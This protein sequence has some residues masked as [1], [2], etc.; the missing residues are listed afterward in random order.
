APPATLCLRVDALEE[1]D[2]VTIVGL[3][4]RQRR[5][6]LAGGKRCTEGQRP[7]KSPATGTVFHAAH[8]SA[9]SNSGR[10]SMPPCAASMR[11]SGCGISP[12]TLPESLM[13][14]AM[15]LIEPFGLVCS[16]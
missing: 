10:P 4:A 13:M 7:Q 14:P 3:G 1:P 11:F 16:A 15:S 6:A 12:S 5:L 9:L 8:A 2:C